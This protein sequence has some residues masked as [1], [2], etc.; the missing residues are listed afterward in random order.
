MIVIMN[1]LNKKYVHLVLVHADYNHEMYTD[2]IKEQ[3]TCDFAEGFWS[4]GWEF[5]MTVTWSFSG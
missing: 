3:L 5:N 1:K 4:P 2:I